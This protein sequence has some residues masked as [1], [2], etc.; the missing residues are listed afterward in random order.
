MLQL[1]KDIKVTF[2]TRRWANRRWWIE[3]TKEQK[4]ILFSIKSQKN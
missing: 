4:T 1:E 2:S 3:W